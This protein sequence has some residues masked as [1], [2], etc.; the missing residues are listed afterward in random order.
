MTA[1]SR[2]SGTIPTGAIFNSRP[3]RLGAMAFDRELLHD[4]V[5]RFG[6]TTEPSVNSS[7]ARSVAASS[8][9]SSAIRRFAGA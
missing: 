1:A 6:R 5:Q 3:Y 2:A 4:R 9:S 8:A 7:L